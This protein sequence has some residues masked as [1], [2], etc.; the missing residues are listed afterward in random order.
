MFLFCIELTF[1]P[2]SIVQSEK[3][4]LV[5][6]SHHIPVTIVNPIIALFAVRSYVW[7]EDRSPLR[8]NLALELSSASSKLRSV[9]PHTGSSSCYPILRILPPSEKYVTFALLPVSL[10]QVFIHRK[11]FNVYRFVI[12]DVV[13]VVGLDGGRKRNTAGCSRTRTRCTVDTDGSK[14]FWLHGGHLGLGRL[15]WVCSRRG[16]DHYIGHFG[17]A[18]KPDLRTILIHSKMS[19]QADKSFNYFP[20]RPR[21]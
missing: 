19:S 9:P 14:E 16:I 4:L 11:I 7:S 1:D 21:N 6:R 8:R 5:D 3:L 10:P 15:F 12:V 13:D 17:P 18:L 2:N 20:R